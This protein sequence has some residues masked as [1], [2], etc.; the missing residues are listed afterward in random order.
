MMRRRVLMAL[1]AG[2]ALTVGAFLVSS[3]AGPS[4]VPVI[5]APPS[6]PSTVS[7]VTPYDDLL[8]EAWRAGRHGCAA[9][10][11]IAVDHLAAVLMRELDAPQLDARIAAS[12]WV[13]AH[14]A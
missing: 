12:Q 6:G 4:A 10:T 1:A 7:S 5:P 9:P 13:S 8:D 2:K 14:C 3:C 11:Q